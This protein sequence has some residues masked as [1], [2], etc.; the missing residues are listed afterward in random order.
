M[1]LV[2]LV[3]YLLTGSCNSIP[4]VTRLHRYHIFAAVIHLYM[5]TRPIL[6]KVGTGLVLTAPETAAPSWNLA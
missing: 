3:I 1:E 4:P 2:A 5:R 6:G